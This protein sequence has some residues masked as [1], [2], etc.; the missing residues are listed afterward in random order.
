MTIKQAKAEL[1]LVGCTLTKTPFGDYKVKVKGSKL[2]EDYH[3]DDLTDAVQTGLKIAKFHA[4]QIDVLL[5]QPL[6]QPSLQV[7]SLC[8]GIHASPTLNDEID[9]Y[10]ILFF[11]AYELLDQSGKLAFE[12]GKEFIEVK[13]KIKG[14]IDAQ[15]DEQDG[16]QN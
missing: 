13:T 12:S 3:S 14:W 4:V 1:K 7:D 6:P 2:G 10:S 16:L 5:G 15:C 8:A 11:A 9:A